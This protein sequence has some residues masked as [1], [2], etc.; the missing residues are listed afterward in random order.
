MT[1]QETIA[2]LT[3]NEIVNRS[4]LA[5][6]T[7]R[8]GVFSD[9]LTI[10]HTNLSVLR[11][12][13]EFDEELFGAPAALMTLLRIN[14]IDQIL[15][16]LAR[17]WKD[18]TRGT[19]RLDTFRDWLIDSAVVPVHRGAV[20]AALAGAWPSQ[21][22]CATI[23]R[24]RKIRHARLAHQLGTLPLHGG[25]VCVRLDEIEEAAQALGTLYGAMNFGTSQD[26]VFVEF[27]AREDEWVE[28]DFGYVLDRIASGSRWL[29]LP[30]EYP[31]LW[32]K[33]KERLS[34]GQV[35]EINK[36]R[37]RHDLPALP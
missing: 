22:T 12:M 9:D 21:E 27:Q 13:R 2:E 4:L 35:A 25:L 18:K 30:P 15:L 11:Q 16:I 10:A 7:K 28:G 3:P 37:A 26:L 34:E 24:C 36:V 19:V 33:L 31:E 5:E 20:E 29:S 6:Y 8:M 1:G 17:L 23:E 32:L 14:L